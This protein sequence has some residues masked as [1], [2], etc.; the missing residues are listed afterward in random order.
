MFE[1]NLIESTPQTS[2]T[3]GGMPLPL[4]AG[5]HALVIGAVVAASLWFVEDAPEPPVPVIFYP[6]GSPPP[7]GGG[8]KAHSVKQSAAKRAGSISQTIAIPRTISALTPATE[9]STPPGSNVVEQIGDSGDPDG[10]FQGTGDGMDGEIGRGRRIETAIYPGGEVKSPQLVERVEPLYPEVERKLHKE[11]IVILEAI[12]TTDGTV[13][14]IGILK[15]ADVILDEAARR[16]VMQWRY[17]PATLNGRAV[18]VYLT[19]TVTFR[20]H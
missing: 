8:A 4:S 2:R 1:E 19:V 6:P 18:R 20:L 10:V 12:I 14:E 9:S 13:E 7:L 16:A 15:S 17:K 3:L 5:L 11:G